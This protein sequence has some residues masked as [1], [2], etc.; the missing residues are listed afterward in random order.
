MSIFGWSYPPGCHGTPYDEDYP[1]EVCSKY[2]SECKCIEC[3][4][5]GEVG[6]LD[7]YGTHIPEPKEGWPIRNLKDLCSEVGAYH[8]EIESVS[9]RIY[10]D[11][12][13][14]A[15]VATTGLAVQVGS[16]VEGTDRCTEV[17]DLPFPFQKEEFWQAV[18]DVETEADEIWKDTHGCEKCW[19]EGTCDYW[20]NEWKPGEIGG[21]PVDPDCPECSGDG[22]VI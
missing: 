1:C 14:G 8:N 15:W 19:P 21:K 2:E 20:G 9:H 3:P 6:R 4:K 11:T 17:H 18:E 10:K 16:I 5:C 12:A 7:C 22:V 13:C